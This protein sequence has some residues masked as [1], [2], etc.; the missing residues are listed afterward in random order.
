VAAKYL[1]Q[2]H[3]V[4]LVEKSTQPGGLLGSLNFDSPFTFD[5]GT[6][7]VSQTGDQEVDQF[8]FDFIDPRHWY[9]FQIIKAG[10]FFNGHL[11][12]QSPFID[13]R[14]LG[15]S[16]LIKIKQELEALRSTTPPRQFNN[17]YERS[18]FHH[19]QTITELI[20]RPTIHQQ[21]FEKIEELPADF[22]FFTKRVICFDD[23][24]S[25]EKK[26]LPFYDERIAFNTYDQ[27]V[28]N[29][30]HYYPKKGGIEKFTQHL[31]QDIVNN[32]GKILLNSE[33]SELNFSQGQVNAIKINTSHFQ[34]ID[35]LIWT[36]PL[37][38]LLRHLNFP[39][40]KIALKM[41]KVFLVHL[42]ID[43]PYLTN[44]YY[45]SNFDN[46][47]KTFR[48]TLYN[49]IQ[50]DSSEYRLTVEIILPEA[51]SDME[52][53]EQLIFEELIKLKIIDPHCQLLF[54]K[55]IKAPSGF[56]VL[57]H[58][59]DQAVREQI[60]LV[61]S[62]FENITLL[63]KAKNRPFFM[64]EVIKESYVKSKALNLKFLTS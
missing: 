11:Y 32:G 49:N 8:L 22:P 54:Q 13:A 24:E 47:F 45:I 17:L 50:K 31:A 12:D 57:N 56:P 40:K 2:K 64:S 63:G 51:A 18:I 61:E 35:Q 6:H 48:V 26:K 28:G 10:S 59:L 21:F 29:H 19:G 39:V 23:A 7:I 4:T 25:R 52:S 53:P 33:L 20:L 60:Q 9:K 1:S 41:N 27:G 36:A 42:V 30:F 37:F 44:A 3:Q 14:T 38:L 46:N 16:N 62:S 15:Q 5:F 43:R 55:V 34:D 58:D